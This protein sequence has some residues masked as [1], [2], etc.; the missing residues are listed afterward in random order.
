MDDKTKLYVFARKEAVLILL[1]FIV[2]S[3]I[4]FLFGM[5]VGQNLSF[6]LTN[7]TPEE[8]QISPATNLNSR[9]HKDHES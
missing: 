4:S 7:F 1:F 5:A 8:K 3:F 6:G 9:K 2:A